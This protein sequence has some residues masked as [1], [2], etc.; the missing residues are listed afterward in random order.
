MDMTSPPEAI[1]AEESMDVG[2]WL[3]SCAKDPVKF[4][5]EGFKWGEGEL[6]NS[7]G[8]EPWQLWLLEQVRDGIA[9]PSQIV[10]LAVASGHGIGKSTTLAWVVLLSLYTLSD[11]RGI[12]TASSEAMLYT[13]FRAELR[14]WFRRFKAAQ[15]FTMSATS[16][17]SIDPQH[18]Q[19]WRVDLLPNNPSRPE[20]LA[21]ST[22]RGGGSLSSWT[23]R[24]RSSR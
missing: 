15:Y 21:G 2:E 24:V 13:R 23:R 4:V 8:P 5:M 20:A 7:L 10:K 18:E 22:T 14:V 12:V 19:T 16:L 17:T 3:S 9:S 11:T 6:K 1:E